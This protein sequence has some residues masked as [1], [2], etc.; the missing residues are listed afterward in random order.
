MVLGCE[1]RTAVRVRNILRHGNDTE[2]MTIDIWKFGISC[3]CS[4][5]NPR[6]ELCRIYLDQLLIRVWD[7]A[8]FVVQG[9]ESNFQ[10]DT[11]QTLMQNLPSS[12]TD[13]A[14]HVL[15]D[16]VRA[17]AFLISDGVF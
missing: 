8:W 10:T 17:A 5:F 1:E 4:T 3:S 9:K 12:G 2:A 6:T 7:S 13:V 15:V 14:R 16:H 11:F